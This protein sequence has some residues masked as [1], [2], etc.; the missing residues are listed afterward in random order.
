MANKFE[1]PTKEVKMDRFMYITLKERSTGDHI[2]IAKR[3]TPPRGS[4]YCD[5]AETPQHISLV[6]RL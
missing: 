1:V 6:R 5:S 3:Y 4:I 2:S